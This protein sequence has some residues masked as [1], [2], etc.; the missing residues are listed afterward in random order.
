[1]AKE[2]LLKIL[3]EIENDREPSSGFIFLIE[4]NLVSNKTLDF[5][6]EVLKEAIKTTK[7]EKM[8]NKF[9]QIQN[10]IRNIKLEE[11]QDKLK[12]EKE[13]DDMEELLATINE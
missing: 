13:L 12:E 11:E 1:M 10:Q 2:I 7:D 3:H 4:N 9:T 8:K 5:L 6:S